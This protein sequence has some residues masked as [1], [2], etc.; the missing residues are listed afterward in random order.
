MEVDLDQ[1]KATLCR[2]TIDNWRWHLSSALVLTDS[3]NETG[4]DYGNVGSWHQTDMPP[5]SRYVRCL[6][7]GSA[8]GRNTGVKSLCWGFKL[9]GLTWSFV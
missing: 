6:G 2:R 1:G 3:T 9:Q 8:G 7:A 5:W 4:N